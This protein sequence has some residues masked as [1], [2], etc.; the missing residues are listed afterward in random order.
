MA[1]AAAELRCPE[2]Q[3]TRVCR[4]GIRYLTT[5][6]TVQRWLCRSCGYRFSNGH[7]GLKDFSKNIMDRQ[8]C[9]FEAKNLDTQTIERVCAGDGNLLSY[10]WLLKS[11]RGLS[12][13]TI[14]LRVSTLK[15]LQKRGVN[16]NN[17]E[18]FETFL[19]TEDLTQA[20]KWQFVA[21]YK[22]YTKIMKIPWEPIKVKYEP[23]APFLPTHEELNQLIGAASKRLAAFLQTALT[24]GA[25]TG[26]LCKL[27]WID[28][29]AE[30][31]TITINNAEKGSR[32]RIIKVPQ[33]TI[34]MLTALKKRHPV[35]V[36]NTKPCNVRIIF[37]NLRRKLAYTQNNPRFL[38][39]HLHTFRHFF[40][41][42]TLRT[43]RDLGYVKY[44]LGHKS[45][46]NTER[47]THLV[48]FGSDKYY[49]A[50]ATTVEE[51]RKLAED[52]WSFFCEVD[53]VKIF[54]KPR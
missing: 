22:S 41:T 24:T 49:S 8:I 45:I 42:E 6:E 15:L 37:Q 39:I 50:T 43:T 31:C 11:K 9:A 16:L 40:A 48:D 17:P 27:R 23:K 44:A 3:S 12:D 20:R 1:E 51:A 33:K 10:A 7:I 54:R 46:V 30:K 21:A 34:A 26:E 53:G 47:Y 13:S 35:Y 2:C 4:D 18:S 5:G 28:I 36:F 38:Q 25:R 32:N 29:D 52:G 14:K 19:A